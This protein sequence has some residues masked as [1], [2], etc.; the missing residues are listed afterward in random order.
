[1]AG[2]DAVR[3]KSGGLKVHV[4]WRCNCPRDAANKRAM[5][6]AKEYGQPIVLLPGMTLHRDL[7]AKFGA[8][9]P[10]VVADGRRIDLDG[11]TAPIE[12]KSW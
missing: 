12:G 1:M 3:E 6:L 5:T 4:L 8:D 7:A 2:L 9:T 10:Y 11:T